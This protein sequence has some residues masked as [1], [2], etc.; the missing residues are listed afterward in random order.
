M[1]VHL[2]KCRC[3]L[4]A[5]APS[6]KKAAKKAKS[7]GKSL[8]PICFPFVRRDSDAQSCLCRT[9]PSGSHVRQC[10]LA[11]RPPTHPNSTATAGMSAGSSRINADEL[12]Q[13]DSVDLEGVV[14]L[15]D[16]GDFGGDVG[17][18]D[19]L[20]DGRGGGFTAAAPSRA[21]QVKFI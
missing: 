7:T 20:M 19:I 4:Q 17:Q 13:M 2:P 5:D 14:G 21:V 11:G 1:S 12:H 18:F 6:A 16:L 10:L 3:T 9:W 15:E 8:L